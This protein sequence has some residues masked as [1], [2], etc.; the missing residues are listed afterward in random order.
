MPREVA[1]R[2][3]MR[4]RCWISDCGDLVPRA[5][6]RGFRRKQVYFR[7]DAR[8]PIPNGRVP[9]RAS[10]QVENY[11]EYA[12]AK[13][14]LV[15]Y[16][17][18]RD[19][20]ERAIRSGGCDVFELCQR[21]LDRLTQRIDRGEIG[22]RTRRGHREALAKWCEWTPK[23]SLEVMGRLAASKVV[24]A[25]LE[26]WIGDML[27]RGCSA[28]YASRLAASVRACWTDS[29][30]VGDLDRDPFTAVKRPRGKV[31]TGRRVDRD[32][33]IRWWR[34]QWSRSRRR[35]GSQRHWDRLALLLVRAIADSGCRPGE[36]CGA[37][38]ADV[39]WEHLAIVLR[40]HKTVRKSGKP[41]VVLLPERWRRMLRLIQTHSASEW[42]FP[43]RAVA[44]RGS[45]EQR[46][47][48]GSPWNPTALA[49]KVRKAGCPFQ[50]YDLRREFVSRA[51]DGGLTSTQVAGL[52]GNSSAIVER[53]YTSR[54]LGSLRR[55]ADQATG[56]RKPPT[57]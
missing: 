6:G 51:I 16:L 15:V 10:W 8:G 38:W 9:T 43:H 28:H 22:A 7:E 56:K 55:D 42:I 54:S 35:A 1:V 41:R 5:D 4:D 14:A 40:E 33:A 13:A 36:M 17:T 18:E 25:D 49:Q 47:E 45:R 34:E 31:A 32:L 24:Q 11:P 3:S 52:V 57:P 53:V 50:L 39:D 26:S 21:Y 23:N 46:S 12:R 37:R 30:R 19:R 44:P 20:R 27:A 29:V 2:W 48:A